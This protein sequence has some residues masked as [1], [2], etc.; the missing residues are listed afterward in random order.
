[1]ACN[2]KRSGQ[3]APKT[4]QKRTINGGNGSSPR[5]GFVNGQRRIINRILK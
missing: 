4:I 3:K 1:M 2:C 5:S